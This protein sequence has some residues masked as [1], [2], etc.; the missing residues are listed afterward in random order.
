MT[1]VYCNAVASDL[2]PSRRSQMSDW[3]LDWFVSKD[4]TWNASTP[5]GIGSHSLVKSMLGKVV[6]ENT[7]LDSVVQGH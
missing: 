1:H 5:H 3:F 4:T 7:G 6:L 2:G